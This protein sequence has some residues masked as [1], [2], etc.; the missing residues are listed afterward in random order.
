MSDVPPR[1][2]SYVCVKGDSS[3]VAGVCL[4]HYWEGKA[5]DFDC[6]CERHLRCV[7]SC[8]AECYEAVLDRGKS[9]PDPAPME[10][11]Q[12]QPQSEADEVASE[13]SG[14]RLGIGLRLWHRN[15][16]ILLTWR[17]N[18]S[19]THPWWLTKGGPL[20]YSQWCSQ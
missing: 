7:G 8:Q 2:D 5:E 9:D 6:Y 19:G 4:L 15:L 20:S 11:D 3:C 13:A 1:P 18:S 17:V 16:Q 10:E 14:L 12:Q